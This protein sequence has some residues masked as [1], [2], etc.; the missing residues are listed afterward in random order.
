ME[1]EAVPHDKSFCVSRSMFLL[2]IAVSSIFIITFLL[3]YGFTNWTIGTAE[4]QRP[5]GVMTR[6]VLPFDPERGFV[7]PNYINDTV[8]KCP[9]FA[10]YATNGEPRTVAPLTATQLF[11]YSHAAHDPR[12]YDLMSACM[13]TSLNVSRPDDDEFARELVD[14]VP[15]NRGAGYIFGM[16]ASQGV[17]APLRITIEMNP[18]NVRQA[19]VRWRP[20][21]LP[22]TSGDFERACEAL[23]ALE[24]FDYTLFMSAE[25][26]GR[27]MGELNA[28]LREAAMLAQLSGAPETFEYFH[29]GAANHTYTLEELKGAT[30][31]G[32]IA[33]AASAIENEIERHRTDIEQ[34]GRGVPHIDVLSHWT[35]YANYIATIANFTGGVSPARWRVFGQTVLLLDGMQVGANVMHE[36]APNE[37]QPG[38]NVTVVAFQKISEECAWLSANYLPR[39]TAS[40]LRDAH[41][42]AGVRSVVDDVRGAFL[43]WAERTS[44]DSRTKLEIARKLHAMRVVDG[45]ATDTPLDESMRFPAHPSLHRIVHVARR[46]NWAR[47]LVDGHRAVRDAPLID[48]AKPI[49]YYAST[50]TLVVSGVAG[51]RLFRPGWPRAQVMGA[52]GFEVA[53]AI[54]DIASNSRFAY[55]PDGQI[56]VNYALSD[57]LFTQDASSRDLAAAE[58]AM[59]ACN[60]TSDEVSEYMLALAQHLSGDSQRINRIAG[61]L[62]LHGEQPWCSS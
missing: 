24:R 28:P 22:F 45:S 27:S 62:R 37:L 21:E 20:M 18:A 46:A 47:I 4:V 9:D 51:S 35:P 5:F 52:L 15:S 60:E 29:N 61:A 38:T 19:V 8:P 3:S 14:S 48:T 30:S 59:L 16:L 34:S 42:T 6:A 44:P 31:P 54:L 32:F 55:D 17:D 33:G 1:V 13:R 43:R 56:G 41:G 40:L 57:G 50:N 12:V 7:N 36:M 25:E 11:E 23:F 58:I 2:G 39:Q 49:A 53:R 26:C 10:S